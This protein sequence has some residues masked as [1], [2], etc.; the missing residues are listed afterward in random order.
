[1]NDPLD[2]AIVGGG[3]AG[4]LLARQLS[5]TVPEL[6]IA[7]FEK[8]TQAS[9]KVGE[10]VVELGS[11]YLIRRL[12]LSR[13]LYQHHLPKNGLRYFFD[14]S[15][16]D[17]PLERM[18][19]IGPINLPFHPGFQIDRARLENDLIEMNRTAGVHVERGVLVRA[20]RLGEGASEHSFEL[21]GE[22]G[23]RT[24]RA[25]WLVDAAGRANLVARQLD[26][27]TTEPAHRVGSV[28]GRF[29][30]VADVDDLGPTEWRARVRHTSRGL[31]TLH[32]WYPGYWVWFIPLRA[33]LTSVGVVGEPMVRDPTIRRPSGFRQFLDR[34]R[35]IAALLTDAKEV[36]T[37][38]YS[39]I[40]Y[41]T[42]RFFSAADHWGLSGEAA[43]AADP[44][45]SPGTDFIALEN[46]FLTD[47]IRRESAG[48][49]AA[50]LRERG[51]LYDRFMAF[52]HEACLLLY[53]G[54][55]G[56]LGSY[57]LMR[58]KWDL[59]IGC[60]YN[61]WLSPYMQDQHLDTRWLRGQLRMRGSV[62][63]ALRNFADLFRRL[64]VSFEARGNYF[65]ANEGRFS[66]G[67][68]NLDFIEEVG[69]PRKRRVV[70]A[71]TA[72]IFNG[73]RRQVLEHLSDETSR[74]PAEE[75][76]LPAFMADR[77]LA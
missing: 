29:E 56:A 47:L 71:R 70:N 48:E 49:S 67:L 73:A 63:Q 10:S 46:D 17:L 1:M 54:L 19:E 16:R 42:R 76:P 59:D 53:R 60:Y 41:G 58:I 13:Y 27:R 22:R 31:S 66:Y 43:T 40:A 5:R 6:S 39:Q 75:L 44:L 65:R 23:T 7:V 38:S 68:E 9:F 20:L 34:H 61:L 14:G 55:Y 2:V 30:G 25:R 51:E 18:S 21:V 3:L 52:R 32:F 36:D 37:G 8:N 35:A 74:D 57:E 72:Q 62:L 26:L 4:N 33:G 50:A 24:L 28:W 45:Y 69:L 77:P 64:Q 12:G 11:N 15:G